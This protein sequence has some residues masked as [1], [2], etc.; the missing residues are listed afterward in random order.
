[1]KLP[2]MTWLKPAIRN[3]NKCVKYLLDT[4]ESDVKQDPLWKNMAQCQI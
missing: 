3:V 4:R 1:M 2:D